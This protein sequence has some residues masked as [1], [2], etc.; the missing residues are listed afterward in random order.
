MYLGFSV[1]FARLNDIIG[2]RNALLLAWVIFAGFSL[3]GGLASSLNQLIAF[4]TLQGIG[5]SGLFSLTF[6]VGVA[7]TPLPYYP[8]F[9][10]AV[11]I[12]YAIGSILGK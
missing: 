9:S 4:R 3:A 11:G 10:A 7:F 6:V 8:A 2:G 5:G 1:I 12:S